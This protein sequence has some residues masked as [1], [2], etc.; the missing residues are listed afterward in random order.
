MTEQG[1]DSQG[2]AFLAESGERMA[3]LPKALGDKDASIAPLRPNVVS[4]RVR[5]RT[6]KQEKK[7][8]Q[9]EIRAVAESL[10]T[11]RFRRLRNDTFS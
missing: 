4:L 3:K 2:L 1:I 11:K 10:K 9:H 5:L 6:Q 7:K 8:G